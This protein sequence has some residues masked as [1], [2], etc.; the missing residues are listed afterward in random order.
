[1]DVYCLPDNY[2]H[3]LNNAY[4][5]DT[6]FKDEYQDDVYDA[7]EATLKENDFK[8]IV[9][10]GTG[11]GFKLIKH[12]DKYDTFGID[13]EPTV[14]FLRRQ[15]PEKKWGGLHELPVDG[16]YDVF[17]CSDV[18][19]HIPEPN[20]FLEELLKYDF[21][22]IVFSTPDKLHMYSGLQL[23]MPSNTAHVREWDMIEFNKYLSK[24]F[25]IEKHFKSNEGSNTQIAICSKKII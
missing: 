17:I 18:I 16:R 8:S 24:Y 3:R 22:K 21:K 11:S 25:V 7:A 19:E 9:D 1:M 5:D 10:I 15:Y 12:F 2:S 4:F 6:S 20:G 14:T 13:L 23:G